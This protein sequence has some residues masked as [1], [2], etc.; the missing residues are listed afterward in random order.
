VPTEPG[1]GGEQRA[2]GAARDALD[3]EH[4]RLAL[5]IDP[6]QRRVTGECLVRCTARE[7]I[8]T[9]ELDLAGLAARRVSASSGRELPFVQEGDRLSIA[10]DAPLAAGA[11]V[12]V[13][14][15]YGGEPRKGLAFAGAGR[16]GHAFTCAP[17]EG[18]RSWFPCHDVPSDLATFELAL[19]VPEEWTTAAPGELV[20]HAREAGWRTDT[21]RCHQPCAPHLVSLAAGSF[22]AVE[23]P[24]PGLSIRYLAPTELG[25]LLPGALAVTPS[26]IEF[27][28][29]LTGRA[30]PGSRYDTACVL[31]L[32]V[33]GMAAP[34]SATLAASVLGGPLAR[35]DEPISDLVVHEVAHQW[36]GNLVASRSAPEA[37]LNEGLATCATDLFFEQHAG[38]DAFRERAG[39]RLTRILAARPRGS[40]A[41][42]S[43]TPREPDDLAAMASADEECAARLHLLRFVVGDE[44]FRAALR[45]YVGT[46]A[47]R[48]VS[49][50]HLRSAFESALGVDLTA[51]FAQWFEASG[52]PELEIGWEWDASRARL[53][54]R[55]HQVHA[56]EGGAPQ[57]Y[58]APIEVELRVAGALARHR[59][60]L[61]ARRELFELPCAAQPEWVRVDPHH[62]WPAEIR[63]RRSRAEWRL[64]L[65]EADDLNDRAA[66]ARALARSG[67]EDDA[68]SPLADLC[69]ALADDP[70]RAVRGAAARAL[71]ELREGRAE[72][73]RAAREDAEP[74]VRAAALDALGH[75]VGD[76]ELAELGFE[77]AQDGPSYAVRAAAA[78]L[79]A[80]VDPASA[81]GFL[82]ARLAESA[83]AAAPLDPSGEPWRGLVRALAVCGSRA[84]VTA[85]LG[86]ERLPEPA[87]LEALLAVLET[88]SDPDRIRPVLSRLIRGE[89]PRLRRAAID[90]LVA[91]GDADSLALLEALP[92]GEL[93]PGER[94]AIER[95][96]GHRSVGN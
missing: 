37:W 22:A 1:P 11:P 66:A 51:F 9:L 36:F 77:L 21:W 34:S 55:V 32:P 56:L 64:L 68:P 83:N 4:Y 52:R 13:R 12:E 88:G 35:A 71:G 90:V 27:L 96:L 26:A 20:D 76:R 23:E 75:W 17:A 61:G 42:A 18:A 60:D 63:G 2:R 86:D 31:H 28:S 54:L 53:L 14:I 29:G 81:E 82:R 7:P 74:A 70:A 38:V 69:A 65:R 50:A 48:A 47:G 24:L 93:S 5:R 49:P 41:S 89:A 15:E 46:G 59:I 8:G 84:P 87:R 58:Q 67:E 25:G 16:A 6:D 44:A 45:H 95:A 73:V 79:A 19:T 3:V 33:D 85:V 57:A 30:F 43:G 39:A 91:L 10:L 62:W 72:L 80:R 92:S 78:R 40:R 94:R